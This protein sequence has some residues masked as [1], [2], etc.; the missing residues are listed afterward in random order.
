MEKVYLKE[1]KRE[2]NRVRIIYHNGSELFVRY[3]DFNLTF[4]CI[5]LPFQNDIHLSQRFTA[6]L[7]LFQP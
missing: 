3:E 2:G 4:G 1:W 5:I 6:M 7:H